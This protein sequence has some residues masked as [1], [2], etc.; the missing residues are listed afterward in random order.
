[1]LPTLIFLHNRL[2]VT[3][4]I[5]SVIIGV[6]G[7]WRWRNSGVDGNM[8][9]MLA[10]GE[11]LFVVQAIIGVVMALNG[12]SPARGIVHYLYGVI[13]IIAIPGIYLFTRGRNGKNEALLYAMMAFFLAGVAFRAMT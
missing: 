7:L 5:F 2:F 1:M 13:M 10:L 3:S 8:F 6:Y 12:A 9:G 11:G 4:L